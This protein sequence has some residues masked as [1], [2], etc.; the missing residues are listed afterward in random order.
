MTQFLI[1]N[2]IGLS[3]LIP[4]VSLANTNV[5]HV[6]GYGQWGAGENGYSDGYDEAV[7][8]L[9]DR[10][11]HT[12]APNKG[13]LVSKISVMRNGGYGGLRADADFTCQSST[14]SLHTFTGETARGTDI[15]DPFDV[16]GVGHEYN[17]H[18]PFC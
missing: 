11:N 14:I 2:L 10:A 3:L 8:D 12:C 18:G 6:T 17:C 1:A 5:F 7:S 15:G 9:L 16:I 4:G 13:V